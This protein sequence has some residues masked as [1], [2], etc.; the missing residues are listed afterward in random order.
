MQLLRFLLN[1][2]LVGLAGVALLG[3]STAGC[4]AGADL[5]EDEEIVDEAEQAVVAIAP[6]EVGLTTTPPSGPPQRQ[7]VVFTTQRNYPS[8][9]LIFATAQG[10]AWPDT[11]AISTTGIGTNIFGANLL[12]SDAIA[13]WAQPLK[14]GW[15]EMPALSGQNTQSGR[16]WVGQQMGGSLKTVNVT[17]PKPFAVPP[18]I[19][20]TT[21]GHDHPDTF[22]AT[23]RWVSTTGFVANIWRADG[24]VWSQ[25]L[26]LDWLAWDSVAELAPYG[27]TDGTANVPAPGGKVQTFWVP[28]GKT[29]S[30]PPAVLATARGKDHVDTFAVGAA[31]VSTTGFQ[32]NVARVDANV[33]W[34]QA[35][36]IDWLAIP[37]GSCPTGQE[38]ATNGTCV[39]ASPAPQPPAGVGNTVY[40]RFIPSGGSAAM[41]PGN[42]TFLADVRSTGPVTFTLTSPTDVV[43]SLFGPDG[44]QIAFDDNGAGGTNAR[45]QAS[46]A[47]GTYRVVAATKNLWQHGEFTLSS[48]KAFLRFPQRLEVQRADQFHWVYDDAGTGADGDVAVWRPNLAAYPGYH[49]LGDVAMPGSI[50]RGTYVAKGEGDLLA[51]PID[52]AWAWDDKGSG[53]D[54]DASVWEPIP[55]PGYTCIG[56]VVTLGYGKP[57]T[58]HIRCVK[59]D[60]VLPARGVY[61]WDDNGSGANRDVSFFEALPNDYRTLPLGTFA[62]LPYYGNPGGRAYFALN[63]SAVQSP[64]FWGGPVDAATAQRHA[65]RVWMHGAESFFPSSVDFF[66]ANVHE[67]T[68]GT[69]KYLVTNEALGCSDC[70]NPTFLDGKRPDTNSV[71]VYAQIVNRT[72]PSLTITDVIYW[73]FYPYNLGK[74]VCIGGYDSTI[75]CVG[76]YETYG[77]HVGDWEHVTVRFVDGR[78]E[79]LYLGAHDGGRILYYG[80]KSVGSTNGHSEVYAAYGSHGLYTGE[81]RNYYK[82]LPNGDALADDTHRGMA[83]DTWNN[84]V[85]FS[86]PGTYTGSLGWLNY[87]GFWGNR[88]EDCGLDIAG[89][90]IHDQCVLTGGPRSILQKDISNPAFFPLE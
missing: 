84:V 57:S 44:N 85:T 50:P 86:T 68:W 32:A 42:Q 6:L 56:T 41:A 71:P 31:V 3:A 90:E 67:E 60:Y 4:L 54:H 29:F 59:S 18:K 62:T 13:G 5:P 88:E 73:Q 45:I 76:E 53:G 26:E 55:A 80:D 34:G 25:N 19:I 36:Q 81:G 21:R 38:L 11:F 82:F 63:K 79:L 30:Q 9:P 66:L 43:L 77:H 47:S 14:L 23:T 51:R 7:R 65:P 20:L 27:A 49:S 70:T 1:R 28:F 75:G 40:G 89:I 52:Y 87:T 39:A 8:P 69:E 17:F 22:T 35:L 37:P 33:A 64:E 2:S 61:V 72:H 12:R 74:E 46:L 83:W 16:S 10:G 78:P 58:D 15:M 24:G 48:D